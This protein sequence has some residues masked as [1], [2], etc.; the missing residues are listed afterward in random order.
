MICQSTIDKLIEMRLTS[1][2][3]AFRIQMDDPSMKDIPSEDRF[4]EVLKKYTNPVLLI[5]DEWLLLPFTEKDTPNLLE[6]IHKRH[7]RSSTIFFSQ[8]RE[9]GWYEKLGA[10][11]TPLSDAIMDRISYDSYKIRIESA[12]PTKDISMREVYGLD[13]EK[14]Q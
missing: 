11:D 2:A 10:G 6:L 13:P 4:R 7:R 14:A 9:E 1:M 5:I 3:D 8:Y 12:D